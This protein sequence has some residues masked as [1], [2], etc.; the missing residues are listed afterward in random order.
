MYEQLNIHVLLIVNEGAHG[1]CK[2]HIMCSVINAYQAL[3][4]LFIFEKLGSVLSLLC[5]YPH[6]DD[7]DE[8]LEPLVTTLS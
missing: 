2:S 6:K 4:S 3:L 5:S 1:F 8:K 7:S